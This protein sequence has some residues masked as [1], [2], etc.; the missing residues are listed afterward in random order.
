MEQKR[1]LVVG[2][3]SGVGLAVSKKLVESGADVIIASRSAIKEKKHLQSLDNLKKCS[4][5]S[6][7]ITIENEIKKLLEEVGMFD[8]L[9]ITVKSPLVVSQ[10]LELKQED[11]HHAFDTKFWGQ[12]NFARLAY[13]Y[14]NKGGS[15]TFSSGTLGERPYQG[16]ST[17]SIINGAINSLSKALAIELSPIRVNSVAPGFKT[18]KELEDIIPLGL[19]SD[20]QIANP[21]LFLMN[22]SYVTGTTIVSDGGAVLV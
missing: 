21:Y 15:I 11:V 4:Y 10:F 6:V 8:H 14:I 16:Y 18:I 12:Y 13:K 1:V 7:D 20:S 19:G 5:Y 2:G 17:L 3:S 22:D 9:I